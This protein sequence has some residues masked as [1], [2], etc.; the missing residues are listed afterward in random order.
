VVLL[1]AACAPGPQD[2]GS[3]EPD[4]EAVRP[5]DILVFMVDTL[6]ARELGCYGAQVT[7]TPYID[8]FAAEA[9]L[10]ERAS[11]PSPATRPA[12]A[13][14]ITGVAPYVHGVETLQTYLSEATDRLARLPELLR[15]QGYTTAALVAN[16]NVDTV[17]GFEHGFDVFRGLYRAR[18]GLTPAYAQDLVATAP[19]VVTEVESLIDELPADRPLFLFVLSIDPHA[20]YSPPPPYDGLYDG[21]A[22]GGNAGSM[23]SLIRFDRDLRANGA[24]D[25]SVIVSLYRGEVSYTDAFFG[26]LVRVLESRERLDR[27]LVVF[28]ADHGEEFLEHGRRGHGQAVYEEIS[29][30]PLIVRH[31]GLFGS[32]VRRDDHVDLLD[33]SATL[34][35]AAG[36]PKPSYWLGRDLSQ[37]LTERPVFTTNRIK[38]WQYA[39]VRLGDYKLI[40]NEALETT[41]LYD[42]ANDPQERNPLAPDEGPR[43]ELLAALAAFRE[44]TAILHKQMVSGSISLDEGAVPEEIMEQLKGLGYVEHR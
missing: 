4:S 42:L 20:P 9:E 35:A 43:D 16:P 21:R 11:T 34:L 5:P 28:T 36:V 33:L 13:S 26:K 24:P 18:S 6:R 15:Q 39:A 17:F 14:L 27:T 2:P 32:G 25:P 22:V 44:R 31:P 10:F 3:P 23:N 30:I 1:I 8:R 29:H 38:D 40:D 7:R 37:P 41:E 12:I 19:R